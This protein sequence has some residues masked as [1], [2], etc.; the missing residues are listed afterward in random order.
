M[1][2]VI[3]SPAIMQEW[4]KNRRAEGFKLGLVPTM[5]FLHEGHLSLV[6]KAVEL[7]D[8]VIVSIF[9]NPI[10]FGQGEDFEQYPRDLS[11]DLGLLEREGVDIVF[12]PT[13]REMYPVKF[14]TFV[15]S[16]GLE[17]KLC[18]KSRPGHFRGVTTVVSKLFNICLPDVAVF[19]QKDAQQVMIIEKM[20]RDLNFPVEIVRGAIVREGG[21]LAMSSRNSYLTPEDRE[22]A[23]VLN[24]SLL[25]AE[26]MIHEGMRDPAKVKEAIVNMIGQTPG[27]RID[28]V[29]I[30]SAE[31]LSDL[32]DI[33]GK[34]L[35]ALAVHF[36][37]ARLIDNLVVEV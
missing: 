8:K 26:R 21:G 32:Q 28:Y 10:Q 27:T 9:V 23:T 11:R 30:L 31:D 16:F 17:D 36:S 7:C 5:G 1:M 29:D 13:A 18:G 4:S 20:V 6:K 14:G 37:G 33:S 34:T 15:E 35:I 3:Q 2:D 19:G 22:N 12:A 24:K 25:M